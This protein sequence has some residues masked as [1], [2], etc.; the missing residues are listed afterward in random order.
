[1]LGMTADG[2]TRQPPA[3]TCCL[4]LFTAAVLTAALSSSACYHTCSLAWQ[5]GSYTSEEQALRALCT[6]FDTHASSLNKFNVQAA[7]P[8]VQLDGTQRGWWLASAPA[9]AA[10][11]QVVSKGRRRGSTPRHCRSWRHQPALRWRGGPDSGVWLCCRARCT[12]SQQ[13]RVG[14]NAAMHS[15]WTTGRESILLPQGSTTTPAW[16]THCA[17]ELPP[18]DHLCSSRAKAQRIVSSC[19]IGKGG[20][21]QMSC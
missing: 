12:G 20:R 16:A 8:W 19:R 7:T 2:S 4:C 13:G 5:P 10:A 14:E 17:A 21:A 6:W 11:N 3:K 9:C 1:M 15:G 18:G